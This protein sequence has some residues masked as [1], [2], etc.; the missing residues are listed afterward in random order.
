MSKQVSQVDLDQIVNKFRKLPQHSLIALKS[1]ITEVKFPKGKILLHADKVERNLYFLKRGIVRAYADQA[2]GPVTFWFGQEGDVL[3]SMK[4][5]IVNEKGYENIELL[6]DCELYAIPTKKLKELYQVDI[7]LANWGRKV[8]EHEFLKTEQR[9]IS[10]Q[11]KTAQERYNELINTQPELFKRVQ[12]GYIASY[13]GM[14]QVSL[15]RIR[16][17]VK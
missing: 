9:L 15:S 14:S 5:Y 12:L 7:D 11:F 4:S 17:E 1:H 2:N 16:A 6:E 13:L 10:M 3:V 8:I